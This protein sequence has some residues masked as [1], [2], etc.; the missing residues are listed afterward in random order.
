MKH[1]IF[2][3]SLLLSLEL[4][5]GLEAFS[6]GTQIK[7]F[8]KIAQVDSDTQLDKDH[9]F[10]VV[11]D[12]GKQGDNDAVNRSIDSLARFIN[13]HVQAGIKAENINLA[14]VVHGKAAYDLLNNESYEQE[15]LVS[16]P[17]A[18]LLKDLLGN[19]VDIYLCGQTAAYYSIRN[20][21][22]Y[23]GVKMALSAMTA[24]ALLQ[25]QGYT[26]NPF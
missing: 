16:N 9:K 21:N 11:F 23:S 20:E 17:N 1:F 15:F 8:G 24:H 19:R 7:D 6:N 18:K 22:L 25:Q 12:L 4:S 2:L 5:A 13:M 14:L 26:L 3:A 10:N